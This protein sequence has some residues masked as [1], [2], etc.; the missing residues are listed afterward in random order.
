MEPRT[1]RAF[2]Q[3]AIGDT[4]K[5][6]VLGKIRQHERMNQ[7]C[8]FADLR[9]G[10]VQQLQL[11]AQVGREGLRAVVPAAEFV[12]ARVFA[13]ALAERIFGLRQRQ[14]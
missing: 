1:K 8:R 4:E 7:H 11:V 2:V 3:R 9:I 13:L 12:D 10:R 14:L 5:I 6:V